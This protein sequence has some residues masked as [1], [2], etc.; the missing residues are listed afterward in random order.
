MIPYLF[1]K[2]S[3]AL[4]KFLGLASGRLFEVGANVRGWAH[5]EFSLFSASSNLIF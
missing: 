2:S 4:I 5:I 1:V 3:W